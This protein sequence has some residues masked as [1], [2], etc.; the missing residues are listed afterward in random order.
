MMEEENT[1]EKIQQPNFVIQKIYTKGISF[2]AQETPEVFKSKWQPD[3]NVEVNTHKEM[4]EKNTYEVELTLNITTKNN[5]KVV[6][7]TK[8]TQAGIF[9]VENIPE[10]QLS[11]ILTSY[12]PTSLFPYIKEVIN[13]IVNRA[14]FSNINL[15]PINFDT[16]SITKN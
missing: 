9:T 3:I 13:S 2:E 12:C 5:K 7:L 8:V 16:I 6:Y 14:G 10:D 15:A 1:V 4:L 11:H